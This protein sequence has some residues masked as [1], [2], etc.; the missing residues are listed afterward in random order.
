M[1]RC[2]LTGAS[3]FL[4][5]YLQ[6]ALAKNYTVNTLSRRGTIPCDLSTETPQL[7]EQ[8]DLV[9]HAAGKAHSIPK[10]DEEKKSFFKV[11]AQGTRH[12]LDGL[13]KHQFTG[14]FVFI[15]TVAVYG[16]EI[17]ENIEEVFSLD[18]STPYAQSKIEAEKVLIEASERHNFDLTILRLPLIA[19]NN[20]PG[21]LGSMIDAIQNG[22]YL[23]IA[24]GKA[25]KSIVLAKDVAEL[26]SS[27]NMAN[28]IF[29][30]TDG[31][32]PSF[33][34]LELLISDKLAKRP[35]RNIPMI[36][37][38]LLG[39]VGDILGK[40]FPVN[41]LT[42]KKITSNLTFNDNLARSAMNWS[43]HKVKSQPSLW[44]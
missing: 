43:P 16:Q 44:I 32:H 12:L 1:N 3:G 10:T 8:Y 23:S 34:E 14:R 21:N 17:G 31:D 15:S 28:G 5:Q 18:G 9:V 39:L 42:I 26:V 4:G 2:L 41:S 13:A 27:E 24:G 30:L 22:K 35:P 40:K 25:R 36:L 37:A 29:N 7:S 20:P 6:E 19:G 11:N 33:R 38:R